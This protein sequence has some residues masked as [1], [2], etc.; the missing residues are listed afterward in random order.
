M[1]QIPFKIE[2]TGVAEGDAEESLL[3]LIQVLRTLAKDLHLKIEYPAIIHLDD[4]DIST[5]LNTGLE[6]AKKSA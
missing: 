3:L 2:L 6:E 5:S 4:L 1:K